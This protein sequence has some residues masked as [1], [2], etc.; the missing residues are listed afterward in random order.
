MKRLFYDIETSLGIYSAF[1][2]GYNLNISHKDIIKEPAIICIGY[3]WEGEDDTFCIS[4]R[5]GDDKDI[6]SQFIS[7]LETA[8]EIVAHNGDGFDLPWI[9]GRAI[10]HRLEMRYD[11]PSVDTLKMAKRR[12]GNGFKFQSNRLDYIA[13][14]FGIGR[15]IPTDIT[16]WQDITY[17][18]YL[19]SFY[20]DREVYN[21]ALNKMKV[22]CQMDVALLEEVYK[23]FEPYT[24]R[25]THAA[26]IK[27]GNKWD[28]PTCASGNT[29][30]KSL[31]ILAS[32][33]RRRRMQCKE[34][35]SYFT[36]SLKTEID[37][38]TFLIDLQRYKL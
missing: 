15:K 29:I 28:C 16:L 37:R 1:R 31:R 12:A 18:C 23:I 22:Y 36:L 32:G 30:K 13:S 27:G 19:N 20:N 24:P 34:C 17:Y 38:D 6:I 35:N 33:I 8:D 7:I 14:Y 21:E 26:I 10:K 3:K 5:D 4:W 9:R 25:K 2:A 11:Y